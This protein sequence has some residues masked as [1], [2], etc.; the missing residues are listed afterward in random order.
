VNGAGEAELRERFGFA[1]TRAE[2]GAPE[3][4]LCASGIE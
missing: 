1:L 3:Q 2:A 4:A